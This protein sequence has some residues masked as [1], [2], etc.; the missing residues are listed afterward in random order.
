VTDKH[1]VNDN[2]FIIMM[3]MMMMMMMMKYFQ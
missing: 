3:M 1:N 2:K